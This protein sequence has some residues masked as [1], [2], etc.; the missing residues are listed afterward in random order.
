MPK[1]LSR[2]Q[3]M[4]LHNSRQ[5]L[6]G[7]WVST[8]ARRTPN[9]IALTY[10]GKHL[11][12]F[13]LDRRVN[14]LGNGLMDL[15]IL[16]GDKVSFIMQNCFEIV[17]CHYGIPRIGALAV[18]L[19]YRL[20][21]REFIYHIND[22]DSVVVIFEK[23]Y[24]EMINSIRS[25]LHKV[26]NYICVGNGGPDWAINYEELLEKS[27]LEHPIV[28]MKD[29]DDAYIEFTSG[30]TGRAKGT[31]LTHKSCYVAAL[32]EVGV[33]H[34]DKHER[35]LTVLPLYFCGGF[36][37]Q[38]FAVNMV[39]GR[40]C[41]LRTFDPKAVMELVENEKLTTVHQV[42]A[43]HNF[44]MQIENLK[45]YDTTSVIRVITG[46]SIT[47]V[48]LKQKLLDTFPNAVIYDQYGLSETACPA[49]CTT[50]DISMEKPTSIGWPMQIVDVQVW[51]NDCKPVPANERGELVMRSP[52]I[53]KEYYK[54]PEKTAEVFEGG[55]FHTGDIAS[56]DEDGVFYLVDR[57]KDMI[58]TGGQNV[59][60]AEVEEVLNSHPKILESAVI[61]IPDPQWEEAITAVVVIKKGDTL[62]EKEIID[63][64][65]KNIAHYKAPRS[66]IFRD[67][68]PRSATGKALRY[69]LREEYGGGVAHR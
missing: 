16:K 29:D 57:K 25:E 23:M 18:P 15:G 68:L 19:N 31:M 28:L 14:S 62:T 30:T 36:I 27:S 50:P 66:V 37:F 49:I 4:E 40:C 33:Y 2:R 56:R 35:N 26:K 63:Y 48:T 24:E 22:S 54:S 12:F 6:I 67:A 42:P 69:V 41:I 38:P 13:E 51:D 46:G 10:E 39:G 21:P 43:M 11:S 20:A 60:S 65:R 1:K 45:D 9:G 58:V 5:L 53:M 8:W 32:N 17:E 3:E 34:L 59:Y 44:M 61:G 55:W 47:P 52:M 64:C 7:S